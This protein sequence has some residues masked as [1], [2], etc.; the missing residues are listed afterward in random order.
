MNSEHVIKTLK[1]HHADLRRRGVLHVDLFGSVARGDDHPD[2]DIDI[3]VE[4]DPEAEM[5]VYA[6]V[7]LKQYIGALFDRP[8]DVVNREALKPYVR[9]A[10]ADALNVF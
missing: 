4:I 6:Y 9:P 2:S 3:M 7:A 10:L 8:V 5:D 1:R